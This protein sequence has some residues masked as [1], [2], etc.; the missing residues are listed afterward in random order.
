MAGHAQR[1]YDLGAPGEGREGD[2]C[3]AVLATLAST[4]ATAPDAG[5]SKETHFGGD[6]PDDSDSDACLEAY[7]AT[8]APAGGSTNE[9][10]FG[11]AFSDDSRS[12]VDL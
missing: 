1:E 8:A 4:A 6:Y 11:G 10:H 9:G 12:D 7:A 3:V 2:G 5:M